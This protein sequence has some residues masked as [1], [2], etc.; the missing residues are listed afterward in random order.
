MLRVPHLP[1]DNRWLVLALTLRFSHIPIRE[2]SGLVIDISQ[3]GFNF[4]E[5]NDVFKK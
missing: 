4:C 2:G 5:I 3:P 1:A